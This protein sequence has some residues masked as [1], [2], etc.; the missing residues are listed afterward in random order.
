MG[1]F[2]LGRVQQVNFHVKNDWVENNLRQAILYILEVA[3]L[4]SKEIRNFKRLPQY[5]FQN[6]KYKYKLLSLFQ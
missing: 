1:Y 3:A 4:F 5:R 2:S 6:M